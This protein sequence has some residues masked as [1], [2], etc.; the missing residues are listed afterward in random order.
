MFKQTALITLTD[1]NPT[2]RDFVSAQLREFAPDS[3][4]GT[5][6]PN[7]SHGGDLVWH[8]H[9]VDRD[10]WN[11]SG[12]FAFLDT[13]EATPAVAHIDAV[14]YVP[15]LIVLG[16]PAIADA[17]YRTLFVQVIPG[18]KV[19]AIDQ[20]L[21]EIAAMPAYIPEIRNAA[22]SIA[23]VARGALNWTH[24]WEQEFAEIADLTGPYMTS[25]YHWSHID[26]WFDPEMPDRI[27]DPLL[28]HSA[29]TLP[30]GVIA[31]Y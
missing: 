8:L 12:A 5:G 20:W 25:A 29:S 16:E 22:L 4:V 1:A 14:G 3:V 24:I 31:E 27:I 26:R 13:L 28:C 17:V 21:V 11:A 19:A 6:L 2:T 7:S 10:G 18:S 15:N 9:F 23:V 30:N